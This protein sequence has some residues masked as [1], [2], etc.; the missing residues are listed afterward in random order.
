ME[1]GQNNAKHKQVDRN[2]SIL[3]GESGL[4]NHR[5]GSPFPEIKETRE[6]YGMEHGAEQEIMIDPAELSELGEQ[7]REFIR[8]YLE[9]SAYRKD[10]GRNKDINR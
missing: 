10:K 5:Q 4:V 9:F 7:E 6:G 1:K 3:L 2:R 8:E